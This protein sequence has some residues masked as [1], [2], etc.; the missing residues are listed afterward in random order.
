MN[1][2]NVGL[3]MVPCRKSCRCHDC[4]IE[5]RDKQIKAQAAEIKKYNDIKNLVA[6]L[7]ENLEELNK[8]EF[9]PLKLLKNAAAVRQAIEGGTDDHPL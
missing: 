8:E 6:E 3:G 9:L 4:E 7:L 1:D 2:T 5:R